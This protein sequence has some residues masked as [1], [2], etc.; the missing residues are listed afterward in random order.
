MKREIP[1]RLVWLALYVGTIVCGVASAQAPRRAHA[2]GAFPRLS[3]QADQA[4]EANDLNRAIQLYHQALAIRPRWAEGWWALGTIYYDRNVYAEAAHALQRLIAVDP[5]HGTGHAMLGLCQFELG[6]DSAALRNIQV[7]R[8]LGLSKNDDLRNVVLY[9][10]GLLFLRKSKFSSAQEA[11]TTL[12]RSG[13]QEDSAALALGMSVLLVKPENFPP[14]GSLGREIIL[15]TGR[16]EMWAATKKFEEA[17]RMYSAVVES[18][19]N[20]PNLHYA[21]G[22]FL[23]LLHE[24]DEAVTQFH[25]EIE[26]SPR[27][28]QA[29][30]EIAAVRYRIDSAAGVKYAEEAVRLDPR[31]P[32]GHYLLGL[33]YLDSGQ[34]SKAVPEL[35]TAAGMV[36]KEA[37]F[38]FALGNAY[39]KAGRKEDATRA[40]ANFFRLSREHPSSAEPSAYGEQQPLQLD[41]GASPASKGEERQRP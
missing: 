5:Q 33:L 12:A 27:H 7:A 20:F 29:H 18:A 4:R 41:S 34:V 26:N 30:L 39:A 10:E 23:L 8:Q 28:V 13:V 25:L 22:R 24:I 15:R 14:E 6:Q 32:F 9:H 37:Q 21:Y 31:L 36:P 1:L 16:A 17:K 2:E 19:A 40:R 11:L 3:Q 35:Q 38:Q